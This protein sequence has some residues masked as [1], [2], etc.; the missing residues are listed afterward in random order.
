MR[1]T[2][3]SSWHASASHSAFHGEPEYA[4]DSDRATRWANGGDPDSGA[5]QVP[6]QWFLLDV[7]T[8]QLLSRV[9]LDHHGTYT[10]YTNDWPRGVRA[11]ATVDGDTW[12]PVAAS[13]AGP[14]QPV[15]VRFD[16]PQLIK[17]IRLELTERHSPEWW[18]IHEI[19]V[20]G[21]AG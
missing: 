20:F 19:Y 3:L 13:Q 14:N 5:G 21:P 4:L 6:G 15:T 1:F 16:P 9:V 11:T 17:A 8:P 10:I 7:G 12:S 2:P 18:S